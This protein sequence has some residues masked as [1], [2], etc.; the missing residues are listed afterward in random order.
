MCSKARQEN[1]VCMSSWTKTGVRAWDFKGQRDRFKGIW[2]E[3]MFG[4]QM[5]AEP[6]RNNEGAQRG[7]FTDCHT[8]ACPVHIMI[9]SLRWRLPSWS[10]YSTWIPF[11]QLGVGGQ[12]PSFLALGWSWLWNNLHVP[13]AHLGGEACPGSLQCPSWN[14]QSSPVSFVWRINPDAVFLKARDCWHDHRHCAHSSLGYSL[15]LLDPLVKG[16]T[17]SGNIIFCKVYP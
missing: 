8:P 12:S 15:W 10:G 17:I 14:V 16:K 3:P 1:E 6:P 7:V 2:K 9:Q 13:M 5:F 11:M 4:K